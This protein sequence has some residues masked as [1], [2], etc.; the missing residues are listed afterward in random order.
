MGQGALGRKEIEN[1][2]ISPQVVCTAA[3]EATHRRQSHAH[4]APKEDDIYGMLTEILDTDE[5]RSDVQ[6]QVVPE[7]R[8]TLGNELDDSTKERRATE[9][10][11]TNWL[12]QDWRIRNCPGKKVLSRLRKSLQDKYAI[13][14]TPSLLVAALRECPEDIER[15]VSML[16]GA[17]VE[18]HKH[19]TLGTCRVAE[20]TRLTMPRTR[21][22]TSPSREHE[23]R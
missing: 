14:V 5:I 16:S 17:F 18:L 19:R 10:F 7:Y 6:Y 15:V 22:C 11:N 1:Y 9:W 3:E 4:N 2:I 8:D 21:T 23:Q 20:E 12:D 13:T